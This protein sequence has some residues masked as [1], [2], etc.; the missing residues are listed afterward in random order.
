M[1][2]LKAPKALS[3]SNAGVAMTEAPKIS[4]QSVSTTSLSFSSSFLSAIIV[5]TR[6]SACLVATSS[7]ACIL[8]SSLV[9]SNQEQKQRAK[10]LAEV[11]CFNA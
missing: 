5:L 7:F 8:A 1:F 10:N 3:R 6:T 4:F 2:K 11:L 9:S